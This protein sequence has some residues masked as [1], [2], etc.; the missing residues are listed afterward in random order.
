MPRFWEPL[1][2]FRELNEFYSYEPSTGQV[3]LKKKRCNA[4]A[5]RVGKSIGNLRKRGKRL[6]WTLT[7]KGANF[8]LSRV[9]WVLMTKTDPGPLHVEH[10]NRDSTDNSWVN[11]RLATPAQNGWNQ[12]SLGFSKRSDSGKYRAR[13]TVENKRINLGSFNTQEEARNAVNE[14]RKKHHQEYACFALE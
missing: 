7:H 2:S 14:A 1:P 8:Y 6:V 9:I 3:Y 4:D 5:K 13:I 11:L 12:V 10:K